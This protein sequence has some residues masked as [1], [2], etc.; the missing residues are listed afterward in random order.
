MELVK[1]WGG[2]R[3]NPHTYF[4]AFFSKNDYTYRYIFN[5]DAY[6]SVIKLGNEMCIKGED[7]R[8]F[9]RNGKRYLISFIFVG[10]FA[11]T[12]HFLVNYDTGEYEKYIVNEPNFFY[13]KNWG[14]FVTPDQSLYIIHAFDPFTILKDGRVLFSKETHLEK[15]KSDNF[16]K[17][18]CCSN[19]TIHK[20]LI[21]GFG[22]S[23]ELNSYEPFIWVIDTKN[24]TLKI[25]KFS[26]DFE[27]YTM[28]HFTSIWKEDNETYV[29]VWDLD[30]D[31]SIEQ[32]I[33]T[34]TSI[35]KFNFEKLTENLIWRTFDIP[36]ISLIRGVNTT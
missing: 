32:D 19:G 11:T 25:S 7:P 16:C 27:G 18:R 4:P 26:Y 1:T 2:P 31:V 34:R 23:D 35:F 6:N 5:H 28:S 17:W 12:P 9:V 8:P 29:G 21:Y 24:L 13:G 15:K 30:Q 36:E 14:P 22:H 20:E 33:K 3:E 10:N